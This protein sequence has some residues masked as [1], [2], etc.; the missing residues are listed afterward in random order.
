MG[1]VK[2]GKIEIGMFPIPQRLRRKEKT[3]AEEIASHQPEVT[4][5]ADEENKEKIF[6]ILSKA[7]Y[8]IKKKGQE[9]SEITPAKPGKV[10]VKPK[11]FAQVLEGVI[12]DQMTKVDLDI[13]LELKDKATVKIGGEL[14]EIKK[15][16]LSIKSTQKK[17]QTKEPEQP[18]DDGGIGELFNPK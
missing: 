2:M 12:Y 7:G 6:Q 4:S 8:D 5:V 10:R 15:A 16:K 1:L 11:T 14:W 9:K 13:A 3:S 17:M 18:I